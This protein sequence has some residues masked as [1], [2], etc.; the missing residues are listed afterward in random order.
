MECHLILWRRASQRSEIADLL[1]YRTKH[2]VDLRKDGGLQIKMH[3]WNKLGNGTRSIRVELSIISR[4]Y[5]VAYELVQLLTIAY[6]RNPITFS[7]SVFNVF[8]WFTLQCSD[9]PGSWRTGLKNIQQMHTEIY[10]TSNQRHH[11]LLWSYISYRV[12]ALIV[13]QVNILNWQISLFPSFLK[14]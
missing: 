6:N 13:Q 12:C 3:P 11:I 9:I 5:R 1:V 7:S 8:E 10:T 2:M 14:R 4:K